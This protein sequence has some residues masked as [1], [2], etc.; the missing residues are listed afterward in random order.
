MIAAFQNLQAEQQAVKESMALTAGSFGTE[1][2]K[3]VDSV[4]DA[5]QKMNKDNLAAASAQATMQA[6]VNK[7]S[8]YTGPVQSAA[9]RVAMAAV[10]ELNRSLNALGTRVTLN[11]TSVSVRT[12]GTSIGDLRKQEY[13]GYAIG[14]NYAA[15]GVGLVGEL[16]PELVYFNGGETVITASE[17]REI[18]REM[19]FLR[20]LLPG[21][22]AGTAN[23]GGIRTAVIPVPVAPAPINAQFDAY[24]FAPDRGDD[25]NGGAFT[26]SP[27][28][29][30]TVNGNGAN[31][32]NLE[33]VLQ[34]HDE[35]LQEQMDQWWREKQIDSVRRGFR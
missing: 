32:S 21:Y 2:N 24:S 16:G 20:E 9:N 34:K 15:K 25:A 35:D 26:F 1:M 5:V 29:H 23:L 33:A 12:V 14:T 27:V 8:E 22:A 31:D 10:N 30:I 13:S 19:S 4:E 17:T 18:L 6:F 11:G 28:Y 3:M 7:I